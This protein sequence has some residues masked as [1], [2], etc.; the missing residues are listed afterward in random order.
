MAATLAVAGCGQPQPAAN[1][2]SSL[3]A[4]ER[5]DD[6]LEAKGGSASWGLF[7]I[8]AHDND[9]SSSDYN[10]QQ[11]AQALASTSGLFSAIVLDTPG[12]GGVQ[13]M[14]Y[15]G[16]WI[17]SK[18]KE[19]NSGSAAFVGTFLTWT[20]KNFPTQQKM[21]VLADHG[22]GIVRGIMV[23]DSSGHA[24]ID[25][26][27]LAGVLQQQPVDILA[28]DACLMQMLEVSYELRQGTKVVVAAESVTYAGSWP[29]AQV[30]AAI[31][32]GGNAEAVARRVVDAIGPQVYRS[33][34]SGVRTEGASGAATALDRLAK[35]ALA[36]MKAD[37]KLKEDL[38]GAV[39]R[40]QSYKF[41]DDP[42]YSLYNGYRDL[43]STARE[44]TRFP[45][46]EIAG[47]AKDVL[48]A[49]K[50]MVIRSWRDESTYPD[51]NGIAVYAPVDG[52]VDLGYAR[53]SALARDTQWDEFLVALNSRGNFGNPLQKDKYPGSFPTLVYPGRR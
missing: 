2:S 40:G 38:V 19:V 37:P 3:Q 8:V 45:D 27:D 31:A 17:N 20:G 50:A 32:Q 47:A 43:I 9:L 10:Y 33:S 29:Y 18:D 53:K 7:S 6:V 46:A 30:G 21:L 26:P 49:A 34:I 1:V 24:G 41:S 12:Q 16:Q 15:N 23:D 48:D 51:T 14:G 39:S 4:A 11:A 5:L 25:I 13:V 42:H 44:L 52:T 36:R 35:A 22:G 28:F